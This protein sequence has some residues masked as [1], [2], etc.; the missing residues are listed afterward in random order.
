MGGEPSRLFPDD[1]GP[2]VNVGVTTWAQLGAIDGNVLLIINSQDHD[3][4]SVDSVLDELY[5]CAP[6]STVHVIASGAWRNWAADRGIS[7]RRASFTVAPDGSHLELNYFLKRL[8]VARWVA[9]RRFAV[10]VGSLAYSLYNEEVKAIFERRVA[11][12]IG[13]AR[14]LAHALPNRYLYVLDAPAL[15]RRFGRAS[16]LAAYTAAVGH[17]VGDLHAIWLAQG[18]PAI[19]DGAD[20]TDVRAA[21]TRRLGGD[22]LSYD[23]ASAIPLPAVDISPAVAELLSEV[24]GSLVGAAGEIADHLHNLEAR[25]WLMARVRRVLGKA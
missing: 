13:D 1:H 5:G 10:I 19:N 14:F 12:L 6:S 21:L 9:D 7:P 17:L 23:E 16:A 3:R 15:I 20:F 24:R 22:L 18:S 8:E 11:L 4:Q 25:Q 2:D